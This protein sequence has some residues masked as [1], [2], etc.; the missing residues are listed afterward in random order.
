MVWEVQVVHWDG[1]GTRLDI[2]DSMA[3]CAHLGKTDL[4]LP[5]AASM[6]LIAKRNLPCGPRFLWIPPERVRSAASCR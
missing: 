6:D 2:V 5:R 4:A 1:E 3:R